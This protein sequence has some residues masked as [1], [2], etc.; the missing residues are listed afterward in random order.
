[1]PGLKDSVYTKDDV[2][3][4]I[5][6]RKNMLP[7]IIMRR[8]IAK[9][10]HYHHSFLFARG[11]LPCGL[12]NTTPQC[13]RYRVFSAWRSRTL[14]KASL[15]KHLLWLIRKFMNDNQGKNRELGT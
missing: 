15:I 10:K 9:Q 12:S 2:V 8:G 11:G 14:C 7:W 5:K 3:L 1:M 13:P 6:V 4:C